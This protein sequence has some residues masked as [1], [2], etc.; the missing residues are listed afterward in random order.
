[1]RLGTVAAALALL[2]C[3]EK[4]PDATGDGIAI[5]ASLPFTGKEAA[6]GRNFEQAMLLAIEDVNQAGG[7]D[8]VPFQLVARDSNSGSERGLNDLYELLY[9]E[10]VRYL[11]GPDENEMALKIVGDIKS[12]GVL[13]ILPGYAAPTIQRSTTQGAWLRLAPSA[14][15]MGCGLAMH[16]FEEGV[17]TA[18]TLSS[19][20]DYNAAVA[21]AFN[22]IFRKATG[23]S[24]PNVTI[25]SGQSSYATPIRRVF[26]TQA[27]R[28]LLIAY[29]ATAASVVTEWSITDP[30]GVWYLSPL[31]HADV[32]LSNIPYGALDGYFGLSPSLSLDSEC[33]LLEANNDNATSGTINCT[34]DNANAFIKHF[35]SRWDGARPFP[36]AHLYYDAIVLLAMGLQYTHATGN[37][38][39]TER[40]LQQAIRKLNS[41]NNPPVFWDNLV[42]GMQ[43]LANGTPH[44]YVG[45]GAEY[46]FDEYGAAQHVVFDTWTIQKQKF[47][48]TAPY[49]AHCIEY[50]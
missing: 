43:Q 32:F 7:I 49:F 20:E 12:L 47:V 48:E 35:E 25:Q 17:Q 39:P 36:A 22:S 26:D 4:K 24:T 41:P 9:T 38:N 27:E 46:K 18:N 42:D 31:L 21:S 10:Q 5:G 11:V 30:R 23:N 14:F 19:P 29:P 15:A 33:E 40:Q 3:S 6:M 13:N 50:L 8:G 2:G 1:M 37:A 44:R 34:R 45:A 28:T 16:A